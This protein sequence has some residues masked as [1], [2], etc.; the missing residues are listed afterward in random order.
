MTAPQPQPQAQP[1]PWPQQWPVPPHEI[2]D[3][4]PG[5]GVRTPFAAPPTERDRKRLW[6]GLGVGLALLVV[7]CGGGVFGF[8]A[9]VYSQSRAL[10]DE[11]VS[12]VNDY[13]HD[14]SEANY[15]RA[16]ALLCQAHQDNVGLSEYIEGKRVSPAVTTWEV[17]QP[18]V[19]RSEIA[20][21][22][23]LDQIGDRTFIL[24]EDQQ[25]AGLRICGGE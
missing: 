25:A 17:G 20:V 5:P 18:A 13:L 14:L 11:A 1:Q 21:P 6:I 8:G 23:H 15:A 19:G 24:V 3:P 2:P 4:P 7:C 12:V 9:L 22:V 16:Y 10:P